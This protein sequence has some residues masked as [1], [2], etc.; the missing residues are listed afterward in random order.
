MLKFYLYKIHHLTLSTNFMFMKTPNPFQRIIPYLFGL[1][2]LFGCQ[3]VLPVNCNDL[4][5]E[6]TATSTPATQG[7]ADGSISVSAT[8]GQGFS[9]NLNGGPSNTSGVFNNIPAGMYTI[10]GRNSTGC[11]D[12]IQIVVG[13]SNPCS[14]VNITLTTTVTNT[15]TGQSNGIVNATASPAGAYTY[16]IDGLNF[17]A[18]GT[19]TNLA[20]GNYTIIAKNNSGCTGSKAVVVGTTDP[21]TGVTITVNTTKIDPTTGQSNGSITVTSA[22]PGTG[23]TYSINGGAYQA[24]NTFSGLATGNYTISAKSSAGCIGSTT[25]ALGSTNPCAGV[26]ITV[27]ASQI[28]PT[29]GQSNGS[30]T[31]SAAPAGTYT[32]SKDGNNFQASGTFSNL[33][34]GTYTITAKNNNGCIGSR[35]ITLTASNPCTGIN[36]NITPAI[37]NVVPCSTPANNGSITVTASGSTGFTYNNNGG[38]YQAGNLFSGLAAGNYTIGVKDVNGCTSTQ[39]VSIGTANMGPNFT[40][41]RNIIRNNCGGCHLNGGNTAGYNFDNDCSI[42]SKWSQIK[43]YCVSPFTLNRMPTT[44]ALSATLQSQITAWVNAGHRYTD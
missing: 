21:C 24:S 37:A 18:I 31:A 15:T 42:V 17:Q 44:G 16:S 28:N 33:S 29:T 43:V 19:F 25:V 23:F 38:A 1:L 27:S 6:I 5:F 22:T 26:T 32:Y 36:I 40:N 11:A 34:A 9:F 30:I 13:S 4:N 2:F 39:S 7:N 35:Q 10:I 8:G 14:G 20:A 41:V 12:T 3:H